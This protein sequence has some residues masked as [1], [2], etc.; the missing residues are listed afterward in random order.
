MR[1]TNSTLAGAV[2]VALA[3]IACAP[4]SK[5]RVSEGE[6]L[7]DQA[8]SLLDEAERALNEK[9]ADD[10]EWKLRDAHRVLQQPKAASSPDWGSLV[11]R[12]KALE[13]RVGETRAQKA[14]DEI[15]Q[16]VARR[17]EVIAKSVKAFRLA[18]TDL[19]INPSDR[20]NID[21][22]RR[23]GNQMNADIDWEKEL[24]EKDSEFKSYVDALKIDVQTAT[25]QLALAER[26]VE[27]AEGP[28]RDHDE[29]AAMVTRAG[30]DKKLEARVRG[31]QEAQERYRRCSK[32]A[33]ALLAAN[34]GLE[35]AAITVSRRRSTAA[36]VGEACEERGKSLDKRIA[37]AQKMLEE[38]EK[39]AAKKAAK[40]QKRAAR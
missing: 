8:A 29:A 3:V 28:A 18:I 26:A 16:R 5:H 2:V 15:A 22:A 27:F 24:Q 40:K 39:R 14:S 12:H 6:R 30:A 21:A 19:E 9:N 34:P 4:K 1:R 23:A 10:A 7:A 13:S 20:R 11:D 25:K 31:L 36:A 35:K 38:R 32:S 17:R 33:S 37:A